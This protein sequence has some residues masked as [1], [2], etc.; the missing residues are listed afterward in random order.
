MPVAGPADQ[1]I[2]LFIP[3]GLQP[4]LAAGYLLAVFG[5]R[6]GDV[7]PPAGDPELVDAMRR[8]RDDFRAPRL[9]EAGDRDQV[10]EVE[11][12]VRVIEALVAAQDAFDQMQGPFREM[13][14]A[15]RAA[16][17][18]DF[19]G[20]V[21]SPE[22]LRERVQAWQRGE[23]LLNELVVVLMHNQAAGVIWAELFVLPRDRRLDNEG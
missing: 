11:R 4:D 6:I 1:V 13:G 2:L 22:Q 8:A 21:L 9:D 7:I 18:P 20:P 17:P 10:I 23:L 12:L 19:E 3:P 14:A 16:P 15:F 5:D